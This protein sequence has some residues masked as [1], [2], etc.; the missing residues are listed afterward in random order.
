M[1]ICKIVI[2]EMEGA[3]AVVMDADQTSATKAE[4]RMATVLDIGLQGA[5]EIMLK[6]EGEFML[7]GK[8][9]KEKVKE[10]ISKHDV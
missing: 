10:F 4:L 3:V 5:Q 9:I 6:K 8:G 7:E 2:K 1:I